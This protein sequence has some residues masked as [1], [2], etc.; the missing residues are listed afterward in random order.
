MEEIVKQKE[1]KKIVK[2]IIADYAQGRNIDEMNLFNKPDKSEVQELVE[3]LFKIVYPGYF[4]DRTFKIY[5]PENSF[6]VIIEELQEQIDS[7]K[8]EI[9]RLV[10]NQS[11]FKTDADFV[12]R[13]ARQNHRVLPGELVFI[14]EKD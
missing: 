10:E 4:R 1:V 3:N 13:I 2:D 9:E 12:E 11:R 6:S 5:T 14:F 8:R 7:R